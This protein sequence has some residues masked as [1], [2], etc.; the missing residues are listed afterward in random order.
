MSVGKNG[1]ML[2]PLHGQ[3]LSVRHQGLVPWGMHLKRHE[4]IF[5]A[6]DNQN[7]HV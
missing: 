3:K 6:M 7:R 4:S 2:A 1:S 5:G